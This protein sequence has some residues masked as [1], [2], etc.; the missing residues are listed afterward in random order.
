M[1]NGRFVYLFYLII[2]QRLA[3]LA[4]TVHIS[5]QHIIRVQLRI[6]KLGKA[7]L[8][9]HLRMLILELEDLLARTFIHQVLG[10]KAGKVYVDLRSPNILPVY[11]A[12]LRSMLL[13]S[14]VLNN[15]VAV[16]SIS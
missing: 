8:T 15:L 3:L 1:Q 5:I 16:S 11:L 7:L 13:V 14:Q 12:R 9:H 2:D 10:A 4:Q 6:I